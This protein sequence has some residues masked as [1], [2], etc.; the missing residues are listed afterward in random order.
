MSGMKTE[1]TEQIHKLYVQCK[2][3]FVPTLSLLNESSNIYDEEELEFFRVVSDFF[4]QQKQKKI[5][6]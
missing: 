4:L 6:N 5:I 3:T 1:K 2:E